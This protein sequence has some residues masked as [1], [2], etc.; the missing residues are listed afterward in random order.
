MHIRDLLFILIISLL[1]TVLLARGL[2]RQRNPSL[3]MSFF[4]LVFLSLWAGGMWLPAIG[5]SLWGIDWIPSLLLG[6]PMALIA[7]AIIPTARSPRTRTE[8]AQYAEERS[9]KIKVV[10]M[11][12]WIAVIVLTPKKGKSPFPE[13]PLTGPPTEQLSTP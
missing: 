3:L 6:L 13:E 7:T 1:L 5:P 9:E 4:I 8:Q 10:N 12:F 2:R 11:F